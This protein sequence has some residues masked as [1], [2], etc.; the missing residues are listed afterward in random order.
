[1]RSLLQLDYFAFKYVSGIAPSPWV[2]QTGR[3][4]MRVPE[5]REELGRARVRNAAARLSDFYQLDRFVAWTFD[6]DGASISELVWPAQ[7]FHPLAAIAQVNLL[8]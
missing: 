1:M 3:P 6:H 4:S 2:S 8:T 7:T 5:T